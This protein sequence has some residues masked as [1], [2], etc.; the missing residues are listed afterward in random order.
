MK[1]LLFEFTTASYSFNVNL[2]IC[3]VDSI[4]RFIK[5]DNTVIKNSIKP[6]LMGDNNS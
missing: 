1:C 3:N 6:T 5:H 2:N 4:I